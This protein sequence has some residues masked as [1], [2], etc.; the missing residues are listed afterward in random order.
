MKKKDLIYPSSDRA[1]GVHAIIWYKEDSASSARGIVQLAHGMNEYAERY[2]PLAKFLTDNDF[3]VCANDHLGH[4]ETAE[5]V[6]GYMGESDGWLHMI[7]DMKNLREMVSDQS[8]D[9]KPYFLLGHSMGSFLARGYATRYAEGL[10]GLILS[11]TGQYPP[12]ADIYVGILKAVVK[13]NMGKKTAMP[14][15][16]AMLKLMNKRIPNGETGFEWLSR[17]KEL[18]DKLRDDKYM[19]NIFTYAGYLDMF[20]GMKEVSDK[21]WAYSVPK[22]LPIYI[23]SG[24]EDPVG[25][26]SKGVRQVSNRLRAAKCEDVTMRLYEGGRHE[27]LNETNRE[28]VYKD[29]LNWMN[30]RL[31]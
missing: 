25:D 13:M 4:G 3:V 28:E 12:L 9:R 19:K 7:D 22:D 8:G 18:T 31:G 15:A 2:T 26:Y 6:F 30:K 23:F 10:S 24:T 27:M 1:H 29:L 11:G 5:G 21:K 20:S 14:I 17:D 16:K